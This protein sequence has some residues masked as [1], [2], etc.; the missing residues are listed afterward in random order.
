MYFFFKFLLQLGKLQLMSRKLADHP[1]AFQQH[2][3]N[4]SD[5]NHSFNGTLFLIKYLKANK[6][7]GV[8]N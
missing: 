4:G 3:L 6:L 1:M 5:N 8:G 7:K 2:N